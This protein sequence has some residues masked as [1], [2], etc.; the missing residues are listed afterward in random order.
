[1]DADATRA[2]ILAALDAFAATVEPGDVVYFHYSGHGSQVADQNGD[3]PDGLDETICPHDAR[4]EDVPD[5][6]DDELD[7]FVG[8]LQDA[9][10]VVVLDSCHSGTG[11]RDPSFVT[12]SVPRDDRLDLYRVATRAVVPLPSS[13]GYV[14]YTGATAEQSALD[15][16][17]AEGR[18]YGLFSFA[19][20]R[21]LGSAPPGVTPRSLMGGV[22]EALE[23][24][25]H[26]LGN[27]S[28]PDFQLE[29]PSERLDQALFSTPAPEAAGAR[30]PWVEVK[31]VDRGYSLVRGARLGANP[32]SIWAVYP[33]G[34]L[35]FPPGRADARLIVQSTSGDDALASALDGAARI[36]PGARA[37]LIA[38]A[39][40]TTTRSREEVVALLTLGNPSSAMQLE[41]SVAGAPQ[42]AEVAMGLRGVRV[43]PDLSPRPLRFYESEAPRSSHNSLQLALRT[44]ETCFLSIVDVDASGGVSLLFPNPHH[45][46]GLYEG[47]RIPVGEVALLPDSLEPDNRLGF[48]FD[49]GPPPGQDSIRAFCT[50]RRREADAIR[51]VIRALASVQ[52]GGEGR[53]IIADLRRELTESA[54]RG[55]VVVPGAD[56]QQGDPV[57]SDWTAASV[58]LD[59]SANE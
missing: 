59:V 47:G 11:L 25:R 2:G 12:R 34:E 1:M 51:E 58:T 15:G 48:Y 38:S 56:S 44:S 31:K 5:I 16:P 50:T 20:S 6:T 4:S 8:K 54:I 33:P 3:E 42:P 49:Y 18:F 41:L 45:T 9:S 57:A 17:F 19:F 27:R 26:I 39:P 30:L 53:R 23:E 35:R 37:V 22:S 24:A 29:G 7:V 46:S 13:E 32:E 14:L 52:E 28:L 55:L 21:G 36:R 40:S 43:T 10:V